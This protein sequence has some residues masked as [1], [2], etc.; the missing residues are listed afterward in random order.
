[1]AFSPPRTPIPNH[2]ERTRSDYIGE[3]GTSSAERVD[4]REEIKYLQSLGTQMTC[5]PTS[6]VSRPEIMPTARMQMLPTPQPPDQSK[7]SKRRKRTPRGYLCCERVPLLPP[8]LYKAVFAPGE[9][10]INKQTNEKKSG[11]VCG[12]VVPMQSL[13]SIWCRSFQPLLLPNSISC[14]PLTSSRARAPP[15]PRRRAG[16]R[17]RRAAPGPLRGPCRSSRPAWGSR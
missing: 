9:I 14:T 7:V 2:I 13:F 17:S 5:L 4:E 12:L 8:S 1:M 6:P 11:P 16:R 3:N 10:E 15:P